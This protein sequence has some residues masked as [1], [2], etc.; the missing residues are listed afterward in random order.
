MLSKIS[1][2]RLCLRLVGS[3]S[4]NQTQSELSIAMLILWMFGEI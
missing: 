4:T 1:V 2:D 3:I